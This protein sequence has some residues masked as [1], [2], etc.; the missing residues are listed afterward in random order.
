MH[1]GN[2][3]LLY[4]LTALVIPGLS[5]FLAVLAWCGALAVTLWTGR[6]PWRLVWRTRWLF[7][8]LVLGY[9]YS[10]PGAPLLEQ[11]GAWSPSLEGL[12]AGG[13][14]ALHLMALLLWL[15]VLVLSLPQARLM[16]G[17][18]ALTRPLAR[19]GVDTDRIA[20]RLALTLKVIELLEHRHGPASRPVGAQGRGLLAWLTRPVH[21]A[22]IPEQ[23]ELGRSAYQR[24]DYVV[25]LLCMAGMGVWC[26]GQIMT[27]G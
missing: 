18:L 22:D 20:L 21:L 27:H 17:L 3:I 14:R 6:A 15:D 25:A 12:S 19:L 4:I 9:A 7:L 2:R 8:V 13:E 23:V 26:V 16:A 5:F 11:A 1:P 10:L 24:Q